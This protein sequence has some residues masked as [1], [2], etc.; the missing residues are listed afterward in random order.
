MGTH[1]QAQRMTKLMRRHQGTESEIDK[2]DHVNG[3]KKK[4]HAIISICAEKA[5]GKIL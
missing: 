5:F 3:L 1:T 4:S 2:V